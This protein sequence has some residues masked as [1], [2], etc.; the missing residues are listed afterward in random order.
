MG[1][2]P[3]W[4]T[5]TASLVRKSITVAWLF[6]PWTICIAQSVKQFKSGPLDGK[7][8]KF[9]PDPMMY[10]FGWVFIIM[11]LS[12]SWYILAQTADT[13][14]FVVQAILF[15]L[16]IVTAILWMWRYHVNKIDGISIFII[17]LFQLVIL[18]PLA[19]STSVY[20][21]S[22]LMPLLVW[23]IFQLF[24]SAREMENDSIAL[25]K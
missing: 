16:I 20:G 15:F 23:A 25:V 11:C 10:A 22:L 5:T 24:V 8:V 21:A 2:Q 13:L 19:H 4:P 14:A 3:P 9:R 6:A 12:A 7:S 17:L 18:L 1:I